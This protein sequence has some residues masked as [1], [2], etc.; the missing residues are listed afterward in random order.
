MTSIRTVT[1]FLGAFG[2][3]ALALPQGVYGAGPTQGDADL[4]GYRFR[5]R[6]SGG[7]ESSPVQVFDDGRQT[8]FQFASTDPVPRIVAVDE[9]GGRVIP[10]TEVHPPYV[11]VASL[12]SRFEVS[13]VDRSA[14][15]ESVAPVVVEAAGEGRVAL[16]AP[17]SAGQSRAG[18]AFAARPPVDV[19]GAD[20]L[21]QARELYRRAVAQHDAEAERLVL[22]AIRLLDRHSPERPVPGDSLAPPSTLDSKERRPRELAHVVIPGS[23]TSSTAGASVVAPTAMAGVP[24]SA[25]RQGVDRVSPPPTARRS[26]TRYPSV[27]AIATVAS[28]GTPH[29]GLAG[30]VPSV[31][32]GED[33]SGAAAEAMSS[34]RVPPRPEADAQADARTGN[35]QQGDLSGAGSAATEVSRSPAAAD[36]SLVF[37]AA[38]GQRVSEALRAFLA[39]HGWAM[40]WESESDFT[41]RRAYEVRA[42][43][44]EDVLVGVLGDYQLSAVV[45]RGNRVVAVASAEPGRR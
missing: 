45:Y 20:L 17:T 31:H 14:T 34:R 12:A 35:V 27:A 7:G 11:V 44:V 36:A 23:G 18:P 28:I 22:A 6:V 24:S 26:D 25:F 16:A 9:S 15:R 43:T 40:E 10:H 1:G 30:H 29:L 3:A 39:H 13:P 5:Y 19:A 38:P 37:Q 42:V 21:D 4:G 33:R 41:I 32:G 2:A 8:Y